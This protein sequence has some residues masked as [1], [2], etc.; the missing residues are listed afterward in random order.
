MRRGCDPRV[1]T[2]T[3]EVV[4]AV[5]LSFNEIGAGTPLVILHGLFGSKRN[6]S[7]IARILGEQRRVFTVDLRN[8][9]QSPWD[10]SHDYASLAD[11]VARF[12]EERVGSP[13]AVLG[14]SMGGKVAMILAL[15]RPELV[16]RLIVVDIAPA[17]SSGTLIKALHAMKAVPL[18]AYTRRTEVEAA[19]APGATQRTPVRAPRA[20]VVLRRHEEHDRVVLAGTPLVQLGDPAGPELV[21]PVLTADAARIR[22]GM[23][24]TA[25]LSLDG[26][27]LPATVARVEP[28]AFAKVSPLGV[29]E[30]R[31]NVVL[32]AGEGW[33]VVGDAFRVD[34]R[35]R[36]RELADAVSVPVGALVRHDSA[37]AVFVVRGRR[38]TRQAV[39]LALQGRDRAAIATGLAAGDTV[40]VYPGDDIADGV[41]LR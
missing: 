17:A 16:E 29:E 38:V 32:R 21:V 26:A 6:W 3:V 39:T 14:H 2:P 36:V 30:Q 7:S 28:A 12:I 24:A 23:S 41:R 20:G 10:P 35:I 13:A 31:V 18:A 5:D 11:D 1:R 37:W 34:V 8:H 19:L 25:R 22:P 4:V 9:G 15:T 27:P 33:P 40:V